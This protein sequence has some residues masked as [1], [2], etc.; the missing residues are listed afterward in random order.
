[1]ASNKWD[2]VTWLLDLARGL[3]VIGRNDKANHYQETANE[4]ERLRA[5]VGR[6]SSAWGT[7]NR[8]RGRLIDLAIDHQITDDDRDRLVALHELADA[9]LDHVA[10]SK[11]ANGQ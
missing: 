11:Q 1:M 2:E 3:D 5:I 8:E 4:L 9:Y 7:I 10:E 6:L